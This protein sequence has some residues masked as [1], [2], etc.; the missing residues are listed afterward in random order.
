MK[1]SKLLALSAITL[2]GFSACQQE[3]IAPEVTPGETHTVTFVAG[4]PETKT[5][6]DISD[7]TTAK[8]AWTEADEN[9]FTVYENGTAATETIGVLG[10]DGKM[11]LSATFD[12]TTPAS[13][14]YQ[15]LYNTAVSSTQTAN[16]LY[17]ETA[18]VLVSAVLNDIDREAVS[19]FSFKRES[20]IAKMTLK[21]LTDGAFV[22]RVTINSDKAIAGTYDLANG[23]FISTSNTIT[24]T[25]LGEIT[26]G[27]A[28]VWFASVP[29]EDATFTVTATAVDNN[30]NVVATYT[31]TFSKTIT[32]TRGDVKGFGV[33]MTELVDPHKDDNGWFL[34]KDARFL[35]AG[36]VIRIGCASESAVA[37]SLSGDYLTKAGATYDD[38]TESMVGAVSSIDFTLGGTEGAWTLTNS[39]ATLGSTSVKKLALGSDSGAY[40]DTWV[41]TITDTGKASITSTSNTYGTIYYNSS[42]PRFLNYAESFNGAKVPEIYKKYGTPVE[43]KVDQNISF[44]PTNYT[45]TIGAVNTYPTL[46]AQSTGAKT[47]SSSNIEVATIDEATGEI[48]LVAAGTTTISVT[49][50]SDDT[51]NAGTGSYELTVKTAQVSEGEWV[52]T[53]ISEISA[54]DIVV[55]VGSNYGIRNDEGTSSSP[56]VVSVTIT[57]NKITSV[58]PDNI[59]WNIS[60]NSTD[61]YVFYP[62]GETSKWLYCNTTAGKSSND[63]IRVGT[64]DRKQWKPDVNGYFVNTVGGTNKYVDRVLSINGT[65]DWRSY[66]NTNTNPQKLEFYV[67]Q[68]SGS[69]EGGGETGGGETGGKTNYFVKIT[70]APADWSGEYLI[71]CEEGNV[72][73]DGSRTTLDA[74]SNTVSVTISKSN[75]KIEAT[76]ALLKSTFTINADGTT[77]QSKSGY[78]IGQSSDANGLKSSTSTSYDHTLSFTTDGEFTAVSGGAYLRYNSASDQTRF[79]YFKS[80][81]YTGQTAI[82]LYKLE[83]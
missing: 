27:E 73:F 60:G 80:S 54:S 46:T 12:G 44:S 2:L 79:R 45:A 14:S 64:G 28:T 51:Y 11:T 83:N 52:K 38:K 66:V 40:V 81:S 32:L 67:L 63:N 72:A 15:A 25:S 69:S 61:G 1:R 24:I 71:V 21:G 10:E 35:A 18:D 78:Y 65:S 36:D 42:S 43:A 17:D 9:R 68:S 3:E 50:A 20:A 8:F 77:I 22:S 31:K 75:S 74:V 5:T 59:K 39:G 34:V 16:D 57:N 56:D 47:W 6:V 30:E 82:Q 53:D 23:S 29:V 41:I 58:V 76:D 19:Y 55:I 33:A 26:G 7:G 48:S 70:S 37:S 4:A 13:P 49:V 62:N